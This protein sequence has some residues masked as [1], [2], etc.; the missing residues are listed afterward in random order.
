MSMQIKWGKKSRGKWAAYTILVPIQ[1]CLQKKTS[2]FNP[3][4]I[5][6]MIDAN[7]YEIKQVAR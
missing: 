3:K 1:G 7:R 4:E 5:L 6:K 2:K